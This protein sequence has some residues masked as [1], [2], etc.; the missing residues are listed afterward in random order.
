[1]FQPAELSF[2]CGTGTVEGAPLG[3][4][5]RDERVQTTGLPPEALGRASAGRAAPLRPLALEVRPGER[6]GAVLAL[7]SEMVAA[8]DGWGLAERDD[9]LAAALFASLVDSFTS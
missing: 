4:L 7:G 9:R 8:L 1:M 2:D 3:R 5:A 6:P